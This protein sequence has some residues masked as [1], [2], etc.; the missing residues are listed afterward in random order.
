MLVLLVYILPYIGILQQT[1]IILLNNSFKYINFEENRSK[2]GW[3]RI[4]I[5]MCQSGAKCL[6]VQAVVIF[7]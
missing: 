1:G 6:P 5:L 7:Q 2:T 3:F 4:R